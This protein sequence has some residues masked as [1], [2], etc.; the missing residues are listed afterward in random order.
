MNHCN[1]YNVLRLF[2]DCVL[3]ITNALKSKQTEKTPEVNWDINM[4]TSFGS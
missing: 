1:K 3:K 4:F 2:Q